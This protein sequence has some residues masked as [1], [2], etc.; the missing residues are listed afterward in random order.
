M[1]LD[2]TT[3]AGLIKTNVDALDFENGELTNDNVI[4]ALSQ[5]IINHLTTDGEVVVT[6]GSSAGTYGIT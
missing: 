3:L 1:A 4:L 2:A 6:T 5:A